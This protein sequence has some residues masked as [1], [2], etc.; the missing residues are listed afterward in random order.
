MVKYPLPGN[1]SGHTAE[2]LEDYVDS[3]STDVGVMGGDSAHPWLEKL[4]VGSHSEPRRHL[5][6]VKRFHPGAVVRVEYG[7]GTAR[8]MTPNSVLAPT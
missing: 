2:S 5:D 3:E 4:N 1:V 6:V 8:G 7:A